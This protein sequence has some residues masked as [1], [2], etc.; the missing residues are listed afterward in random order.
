MSAAVDRPAPTRSYR[1][2]SCGVE[3]RL[4]L[5][6]PDPADRRPVL[7]ISAKSPPRLICALCRDAGDAP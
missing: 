2:A 7:R 5:A 1:Y 3:G 4:P 6:D